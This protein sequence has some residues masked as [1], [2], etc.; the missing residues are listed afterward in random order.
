MSENSKDKAIRGE[1]VCLHTPLGRGCRCIPPVFE[2]PLYTPGD[3]YTELSDPYNEAYRQFEVIRDRIVDRYAVA[4]FQ[5]DHVGGPWHPGHDRDPLV[6]L[7]SEVLVLGLRLTDCAEDTPELYEVLAEYSNALT[8]WE[9]AHTQVLESITG[10]PDAS[11]E[12]PPDP[13]PNQTQPTDDN[14]PDGG[15][16]L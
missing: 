1:G 14:T 16:S 11:S 8:A 6:K 5:A 4:G 12:V 15:G 7:T 9:S 3:V 10:K 13:P 2:K